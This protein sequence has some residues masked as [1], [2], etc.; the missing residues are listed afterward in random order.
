MVGDP[1]FHIIG[2]GKGCYSIGSIVRTLP[3]LVLAA[4][5]ATLLRFEFIWN[6]LPLLILNSNKIFLAHP[7]FGIVLFVSGKFVTL[8]V[9]FINLFVFVF[10]V[11]HL[12]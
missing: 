3:H 9:V 1:I 7:L 4:A 2:V 8:F 6:R 12:F 11:L 10:G 5:T